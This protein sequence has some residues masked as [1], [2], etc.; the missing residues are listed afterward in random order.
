MLGK[1]LVYA[2]TFVVCILLQAAVAP[3]IALFGAQPNFLLVPVLLVALRS[4][5][6]PASIAGFCLGLLYDA[7]TSG[8]IGCMALVLVLVAW[9]AGA[10]S[11]N[12]AADNVAVALAY[13]VAGALSTECLYAVAVL[14]TTTDTSGALG[15]FVGHALPAFLYTAVFA[16][17]GL[18]TIT[19]VMGEGA[20]YQPRVGRG[21]S[22]RKGLG[23]GRPGGKKGGTPLDSRLH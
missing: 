9:A 1:P 11:A 15:A 21:G 8:T 16:C 3:N 18:A 19:L 13:A 5:T 12:I 6:G 10:L 2:I 7:M 4:G 22:A 17:I 14:L 20:S 23:A